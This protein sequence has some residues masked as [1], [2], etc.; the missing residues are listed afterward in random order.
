MHTVLHFSTT[1]PTLLK[2]HLSLVAIDFVYMYYL[3]V[4]NLFF[5]TDFCS[6]RY[7]YNFFL[8]LEYI[9]ER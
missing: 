9:L 4:D 8:S 7:F 2:H 6:R 3:D 1:H 5:C